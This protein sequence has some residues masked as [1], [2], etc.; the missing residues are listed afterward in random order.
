MG[1]G[2]RSGDCSASWVFPGRGQGGHSSSF[3]CKES[4]KGWGTHTPTLTGRT[5]ESQKGDK[6]TP[7]HRHRDWSTDIQSEKKTKS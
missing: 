4:K 7:T 5:G 1:D 6:M 2:K 3:H